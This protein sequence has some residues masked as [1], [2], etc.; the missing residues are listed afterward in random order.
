MKKL[1]IT[2]GSG[3]L[4][5]HLNLESSEK[6]KFHTIYSNNI[7]NCNQFSSSKININN[8]HELKNIFNIFNP[9]VVIHAA[10]ITN[11]VPFQDQS[12]R[13]YFETNVS[14][15]KSIGELCE[16][17]N[18]KLV[19][20]STDLVYAGYRGPFHTENGKLI[21][22]TL[23]AET[24]LIGEEK[25]RQTCDN[26]LIFRTSLLYGIG[27]HHAR[28]HFQTMVENFKT[29]KPVKLFTDQF[30]TP[31]S[32]K[33]SSKI[34]F[35]LAE[36]DLKAETINLGGTERVSRFELGEILC[37][38]AKFDK[39]LIEKITMDDIPSFPQVEDVSLKIEKLQSFG[40]VPRS[41]EENTAEIIKSP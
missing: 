25:V 30:R 22:A 20:I 34:I 9:D 10:A 12:S 19:Y 17:H 6:V 13:E 23:Y 14:A 11:P 27:L 21:P 37:S 3:L 41:I 32:L 36:T 26:Y 7:G 24:K 39:N 1:L 18:S 35:N 2:G 33:D 28:C 4:G 5:Q 31:V 16:L 29:S 8:K 38:V 40:F 15:T